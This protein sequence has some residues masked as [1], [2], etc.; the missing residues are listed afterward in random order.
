LEAVDELVVRRRLPVNV[1]GPPDVIEDLVEGSKSGVVSPA[2]DVC[3]L[4]I[5]G[6]FAEPFGDELG[7]AGLACTAGTGHNCGVGGLIAGNRFEDTGEM[8]DLRITMLD[9]LGNE[10]STENASITNHFVIGLILRQSYKGDW[11]VSGN[12]PVCM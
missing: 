12:N 3:C 4:D 10:P 5:E 2:V 9:F 6:L 11:V 8:I 7:H 1:D